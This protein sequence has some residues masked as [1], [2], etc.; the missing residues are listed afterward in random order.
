MVHT[1]IF[2][3]TELVKQIE[4]LATKRGQTVTEFVQDCIKLGILAAEI[5]QTPD[6]KLVIS[7]D[8]GDRELLFG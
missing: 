5:E 1:P 2:L 3:R 7:D 4:P 6:A 8:N